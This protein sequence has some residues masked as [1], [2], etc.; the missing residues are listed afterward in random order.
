MLEN[1]PATTHPM[2]VL[3]TGC[4]MLGCLEPEAPGPPF[5]SQHAIADRLLGDR[6]PGDEG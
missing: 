4:S 3:R 6:N 2:D 1:L 5:D